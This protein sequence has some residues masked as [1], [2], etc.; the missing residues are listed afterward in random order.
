M[1]SANDL[2]RAAPRYLGTPYSKMDCQAFVEACLKDIGISKNLPGSNAWYRTMTWVG[3]PE[4]CKQKFGEIPKGAFLYILK[5]CGGE[6][7]KY[8]ADGIGNASHIGIYTGI[9]GA[10]MCGMAMDYGNGD[11]DF[12]NF[13]NG[14]IHSSSSRGCVCTSSFAGKAINGGWNRIGLWDRISYGDDVDKAL[15][16][17]ETPENG[18]QEG[19]AGMTAT[20]YA[21]SGTTVNLRAKPTTA[22]ALVERVPV[23]T[24]VTIISESGDWAYIQVGDEDHVV[25][26]Y[27]MSEYL[28]QDELPPGET[29]Q[30]TVTVDRAWLE[31]V[32]QQIGEY[33]GSQGVI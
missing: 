8:K 16:G 29:Q 12:Y 1:N 30:K 3:T 31:K 11:A 18:I 32:H 25:R 7:E 10:E 20:V 6:P 21:P 24:Q 5:P 33:L 15:S 23:G 2:I 9:S 27:M 13:G 26:G 28:R 22:A 4:Q 17:K 14:A 19:D